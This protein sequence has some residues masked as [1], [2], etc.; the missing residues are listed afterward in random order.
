MYT[1]K[2]D[3]ENIIQEFLEEQ[4]MVMNVVQN[5]QKGRSHPSED[6]SSKVDGQG[7]L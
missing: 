1:I 2:L 3:E 7:N 6:V 4:R 5:I